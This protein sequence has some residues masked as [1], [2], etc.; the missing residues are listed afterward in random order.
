MA[1]F[2]PCGTER[3]TSLAKVVLSS[4]TTRLEIDTEEDECETLDQVLALYRESV[5]IP[6]DATIAV[7]G[8]E[9]V[10][11]DTP[12]SDGDVISATKTTGSKGL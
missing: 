1:Q 9:S 11:G 12:L 8:D 2:C 4:G 6:S 7:N 10:S 5:N 3:V